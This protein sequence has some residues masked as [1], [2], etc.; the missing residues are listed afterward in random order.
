[1]ATS[2]FVG[3]HPTNPKDKP[4]GGH[5]SLRAISAIREEGFPQYLNYW[6]YRNARMRKLGISPHCIP[7][8]I[9]CW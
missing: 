6:R 1:M 3:W 7:R 4:L 8:G 9:D 2:W 5:A